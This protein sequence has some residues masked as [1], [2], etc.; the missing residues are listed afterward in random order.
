[1]AR[2]R[3]VIVVATED[4]ELYHD[5]VAALRERRLTFT[6]VGVDEPIPPSTR[7]VIVGEDDPAPVDTD[8]TVIEAGDEDAH[9]LVDAAVAELVDPAGPTRI[10]VDP[11]NRPGVAVLQGNL[12]VSAF[13]VPVEEAIE[14]IEAIV[15]EEPDAIVRIGDGARLQGSRLVNALDG[16]TVELVDET[17]TTPY[18]GA[19]A[20][21]SGDVLAAVNIATRP[22]T[23]IDHREV[24]P[25]DGELARIQ[26][27][28]RE[29]SPTNR[30]IST[31]LAARV[32]TGEMT[33]DEALAAH[34]GDR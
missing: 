11:G 16:A 8:A 21:G 12:V 31:A 9:Q 4:F 32:A 3:V 26:R 5:A 24:E 7:V 22:G 27:T 17:G 13:Q 28:S 2:R 1:M 19:G 34:R 23:K 20:R 25:T 30:E 29:R 18:V 10:G 6:T 33:I 14:R 15:D